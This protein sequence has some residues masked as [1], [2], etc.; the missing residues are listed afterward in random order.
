MDERVK[1]ALETALSAANCIDPIVARLIPDGGI[2]IS[3][4]GE[5][6]GVTEAI[7]TFR[8]A[9]PMY[10]K[11]ELGTLSNMEYRRRRSEAL[12]DL[13]AASV[14]K[15]V[16]PTSIVPVSEMSAAEYRKFR[17]QTLS[18]LARRGRG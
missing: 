6:T 14:A 16:V 18:T 5:I 8:A 4:S 7:A 9:K 13:R 12:A 10:F 2:K 3:D 17:R 11:P 1:L 15:V